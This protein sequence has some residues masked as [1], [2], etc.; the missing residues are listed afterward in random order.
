M[1]I[2]EDSMPYVYDRSSDKV[3]YKSDFK[4]LNP[5]AILPESEE[6]ADANKL[7]LLTTWN[8]E[9]GPDIGNDSFTNPPT[10]DR[11]DFL[12]FAKPWIKAKKVYISVVNTKP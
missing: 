2:F 4:H 10:E 12:F 8:P 5:K 1:E 11:I 6:W 3:V 9:K 7:T